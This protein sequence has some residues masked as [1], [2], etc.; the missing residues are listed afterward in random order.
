LLDRELFS[1]YMGWIFYYE[2]RHA[3][4]KKRERARVK[5]QYNEGEDK[6]RKGVLDGSTA[7]EYR[8]S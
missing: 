1:L 2:A 5:C 8:R 7:E 4:V 6:H 3:F